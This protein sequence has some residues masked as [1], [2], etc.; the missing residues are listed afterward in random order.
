MCSTSNLYDTFYDKLYPGCN[1]EHHG[2]SHRLIAEY[3]GDGTARIVALKCM[4][5]MS[6]FPR[7]PRG[8]SRCLCRVEVGVDREP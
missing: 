5:S 2:E 4:V 7:D 6:R 3:M 1:C 8:D